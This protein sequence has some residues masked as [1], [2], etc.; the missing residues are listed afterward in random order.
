MRKTKNNFV[1]RLGIA[2]LTAV[3]LSAPVRF[4]LWRLEKVKADWESWVDNGQDF[5]L[6]DTVWEKG[7]HILE[8]SVVV[9]DGATLTIEKGARII[10]KENL[11]ES[12]Y[13]AVGDGKIIADGTQEEKII[14]T[15]EEGS[16]SGFYLLFL[17][18][19]SS[20]RV[21]FFR[22][23]EIQNGGMN[24]DGGGTMSSS[25]KSILNNALAWDGGGNAAVMYVSGKTHFENTRFIN[26]KFADIE[27]DGSFDEENPNDFFEVIN[28]NFEDNQNNAAVISNI[29][30]NLEKSCRDR[31][32]LKNNWYGDENG[33]RGEA[34]DEISQ[35]ESVIGEVTLDDWREN[36]IITDPVVI[37][38]GITASSQWLGDWK[39]DPIT[40]IYDNLVDSLE[41]NGF[42]KNKNLFEFPYDW[43]KN[44]STTAHYLQGK[45]EGVIQK[46]RISKVDVVAHSMGGLV[47]RAYIEEIEGCDYQNTIDQ[48]ITL[49][50][51]HKGSPKAYLNWEAGEGFF[52]FGD[53]LSK[54]HFEQEAEEAGYNNNLQKYIQEKVVS[55]SELLPEYDYLI[56][57]SDG[58]IRKYPDGYPANEFLEELN[59]AVNVEKIKNINFVNITGNLDDTDNTISQIRTVDSTV[60]GK[61]ENGMP[62]NFYDDNTDQG[63]IYGEGDETVPLSSAQGIPSDRIVEIDSTH[64]DLPTKAQCEIFSELTGEQNCE[65]EENWHMKNILL[66]NVFSPIDIQVVAPDGKR[67]GKNFETGEIVNEIDGAYYSGFE[68]QNEFVTIPNPLDG[69]YEVIT[70]GTG[71]GDYRIEATKIFEIENSIEAG[72]ST[73]VLNGKA[74]EG[75]I[76][77]VEV[78]ISENEVEFEIITDLKTIKQN[79]GRYEELGMIRK[80]EAKI[81]NRLLVNLI[82]LEN[83]LETVKDN[84]KLEKE[85]RIRLEKIIVDRLL[86]CIEVVENFIEKQK[87][88]FISK[89]AKES[90]IKSLEYVKNSYNKNN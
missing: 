24:F 2:I 55:L 35:G 28:S 52:S 36:S 71:N 5:I 25:G 68:T 57:A 88:K 11:D 34:E 17:A 67:I 84:K 13:L 16:Q 48:L 74:E 26:N 60:F 87:E 73:A 86:K 53:R 59:S 3:F 14:F 41:N 51:P 80:N 31:I 23:V 45:I 70:Q 66:F 69:E 8:R 27:I 85:N 61:W 33:P 38:P 37:I 29:K 22:Y 46:T 50:T 56:N 90:L 76:E 19:P 79:I 82:R 12:L 39:L 30:C 78:E 89:E 49:G 21:S 18:Y 40:H 10:F 65:Y 42:V 75:K 64:S 20:E 43:R 32:L 62:E 9:E 77:Q 4:D 58:K 54:H 15:S 7:E 83:L 81:L 1:K 72:E 44:N 6:E 63:L 47:A